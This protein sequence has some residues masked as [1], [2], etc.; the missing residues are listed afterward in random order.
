MGLVSA[1]LGDTS[2]V[3]VV[4]V[5]VISASAKV[6]SS[7]AWNAVTEA[8]AG[9]KAVPRRLARP[10]AI[11]LLASEIA[12]V[13]LSVNPATTFEG[14]VAATVLATALTIGVAIALF[15]RTDAHCQ[16]FGSGAPLS[17]QHLYR[18]VL[19]SL[20]AAMGLA[21]HFFSHAPDL[22]VVLTIA[23]AVIGLAAASV[24]I[25]WEDLVWTLAPLFQRNLA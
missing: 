12:T 8:I 22:G 21:L 6:R 25:G 5:F 14:R 13:I 11:L 16:C 7:S 3:A 2:L 1:L 4:I 9:S 23:G 24:I 17:A 20:I 10:S 19:L 18:N 15:R